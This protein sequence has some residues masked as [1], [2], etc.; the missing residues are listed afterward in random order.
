M[1]NFYKIFHFLKPFIKMSKLSLSDSR[2]IWRKFLSIV[3][4]VN[5]VNNDVINDVINDDN[6]LW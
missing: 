5:S 3:I 4:M 6:K 1:S 2:K